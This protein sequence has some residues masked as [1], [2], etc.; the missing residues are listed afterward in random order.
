VISPTIVTVT[1]TA[2][3]LVSMSSGWVLLQNLSTSVVV[4]LGGPLVAAGSGITL[5]ASQATP[6]PIRFFGASNGDPDV[7]YAVAA[8]TTANVAVL[9]TSSGG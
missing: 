6:V 3:P 7:L 2:A 1:T 9:V 4:T 5:P 8:S